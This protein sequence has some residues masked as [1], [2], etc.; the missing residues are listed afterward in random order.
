MFY[1]ECMSGWTLTL[2]SRKAAPT[3]AVLPVNSSAPCGQ[4]MHKASTAKASQLQSHTN[5]RKPIATCALGSGSMRLQHLC[6]CYLLRDSFDSLVRTY[7]DHDHQEGAGQADDTEED[8]G[9]TDVL[10]LLAHKQQASECSAREVG[11]TGLAPPRC[12]INLT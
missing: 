11:R 2:R 12:P 8:L 1:P 4:D 10:L 3:S 5:G 9:Q 6:I 7:R